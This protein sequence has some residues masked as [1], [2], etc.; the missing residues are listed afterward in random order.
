MRVQ[1]RVHTDLGRV[2]LD[3]TPPGLSISRGA[4]AVDIER[5]D[6]Q[7]FT[8]QS[9]YR[10]VVG[11]RMISELGTALHAEALR[12]TSEA[13]AEIATEG[14]T[15]GRIENRDNTIAQ[16]ARGELPEDEGELT[17]RAVPPPRRTT[18]DPG[19]VEVEGR[20]GELRIR[21]QVTPLSIEV[22]RGS[23]T[24]DTEVLPQLNVTA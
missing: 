7:V 24:V 14:D 15:L 21:A 6:A 18:S 5:R 11:V 13:I 22:Q 4:P 20:P 2:L 9:D 10:E 8:D 16:V 17:L 12:A 1:I 3:R 23:V 19:G